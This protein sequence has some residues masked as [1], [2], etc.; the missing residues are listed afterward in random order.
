MVFT[1]SGIVELT[2]VHCVRYCSVEEVFTVSGTVELTGV[3]FTVSGI[4]ELTG[5]HQCVRYCRVEEVFTVS[6]TVELTGVHWCFANATVVAFV[7]LRNPRSNFHCYTQ[8]E[9]THIQKSARKWQLRPFTTSCTKDY[10][11]H[12]LLG[13]PASLNRPI[14]AVDKCS[15]L[16][17]VQLTG[18]RCVRT[19]GHGLRRS[20]RPGLGLGQKA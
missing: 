19:R 11:G 1:V 16:D 12:S 14:Y 7:L 17:T 20:D 10:E 8:R 13:K 6:G 15:L 9:S 4:V 5:V 18:N 3:Q 2:G